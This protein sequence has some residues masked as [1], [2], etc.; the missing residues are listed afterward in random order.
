MLRQYAGILRRLR[1]PDPEQLRQSYHL[2]LTMLGNQGPSSDVV[3][4]LATLWHTYVTRGY[5]AISELGGPR[6]I[7]P[8]FDDAFA[9][10]DLVIGG[11]LVDVKT[12]LEPAL[13]M[14][15]FVDQLLGYVL[16]DVEDRFVIRS[17]GIYLAWQGELLHLPLD[18]ALNLASGQ[19]SFDLPAARRAFQQQIAPAMERSRF[20]KHGSST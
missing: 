20:Y 6:I 9:I 14:G 18:T 3:E 5:A 4:A 10:G 11:T 19:A 17:I 12:Y 8:V 7:R 13:S 2:W 16:C 15:A 1:A